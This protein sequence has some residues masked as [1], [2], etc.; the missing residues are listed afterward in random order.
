ML[1]QI[2]TTARRHLA[3]DGA[4]L[5]L[6]AVARDVGL[7]SS[8]VYRY[9]PSRDDLLTSLIV[10]AYVAMADAAEAAEAAVG[11]EDLRGRFLAV[12]HALRDWSVANPHEYALLYGTPVPG[13]AA[14][15][16]TVE[17]ASRPVVLLSAILRDGV[18]L[19]VLTSPDDGLPAS[20]R[21]EL[22]VLGEVDGFRG[23]PP[24]LLAHGMTA[25]AAVFGL[26]SFELFGR[27]NNT[28]TQFD[29]FFEYQLR[30]IVGQL[31]L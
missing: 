2:K 18:R 28:I 11:R 26:I 29:D 27:F 17:P 24:D 4:N 21:Q 19:G 1:E 13:Y 3:S 25:W 12:A 9:Y 22:D 15:Q 7:V 31:G 5:S 8:A 14:P 6:R 10:D 20:V 16:D 23:L 30:V